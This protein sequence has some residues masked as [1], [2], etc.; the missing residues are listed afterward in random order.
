MKPYFKSPI[1]LTIFILFMI[2]L[3]F[4]LASFGGDAVAYCM[5][6]HHGF[7]EPW[8]TIQTILRISFLVVAIVFITDIIIYNIT[9]HKMI[10]NQQ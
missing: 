6:Y 8:P 3:S 5:G 10:A 4:P 1:H 9:K 7:T 2:S